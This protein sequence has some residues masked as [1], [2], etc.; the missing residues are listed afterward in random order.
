MT[1]R[2]K[3]KET[4]ST[5]SARLRPAWP[6]VGC[7]CCAHLVPLWKLYQMILSQKKKKINGNECR[8]MFVLVFQE[9]RSIF[10]FIV[11]GSREIGMQHMQRSIIVIIIV[12]NPQLNCQLL[13]VNILIISEVIARNCCTKKAIKPNYRMSLF[14]CFG[15]GRGRNAVSPFARIISELFEFQRI[16]ILHE[17]LCFCPYFASLPLLAF[18]LLLMG[19]EVTLWNWKRSG[20]LRNAITIFNGK[21]R[22]THSWRKFIQPGDALAHCFS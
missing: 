16:K 18:Q 2:P 22:N 10:A 5:L 3:R 19:I 17:I 4:W 1:Q 8:S 11:S 21:K 15:A 13:L 12:R 20:Q 7:G 9:W 14:P 6:D